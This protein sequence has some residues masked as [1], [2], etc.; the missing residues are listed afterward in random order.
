MKSDGLSP[1]MVH[2]VHAIANEYVNTEH[3]SAARLADAG[4]FYQETR[5][6]VGIVS[7]TLG[8]QKKVL[9]GDDAFQQ[10]LNR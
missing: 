10:L 3:F 4:C 8:S 7:P 1:S 6:R 2:H 5:H 9:I